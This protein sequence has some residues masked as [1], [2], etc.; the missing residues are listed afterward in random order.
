MGLTERR[1]AKEFET[2][3]YPELK[4]RVE[5][6]AGFPVEI[7]V[8]WDT[9]VVV[10][11]SRLFKECWSKIYFEPLIAA[12]K[13]IGRDDMG[14][15]AL[16]SQVKKIVIKN[17]AGSIYPDGRITFSDGVLTLDHTPLEN[18][19]DVDVRAKDLVT[20]LEAQL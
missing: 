14:K 4:S 15:E 1:A 9:L 5:E 10:G 13:E 19:N 3:D 20:T 11:E 8:V 18:A 12:L 16:R 17:E 7:E 2:K 6:A